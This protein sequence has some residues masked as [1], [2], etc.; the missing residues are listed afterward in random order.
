M[1]VRERHEAGGEVVNEL[2]SL[3]TDG[4]AE[5]RVIASGHDFYAAPRLSPDGRRVAWLSWDHPGMPWD[6][7]ELW[8]AEL[9]ADGGVTGERLVAGGPDE[10]VLQPLWS[11]TGALWFASDRTGWWNLYAVEADPAGGGASGTSAGGRPE[12][13]PLVTRA[14]EFA[15][16]PW[17]FGLQSYAFLSDGRLLVS[18]TEDGR[19]HLAVLD[20]PEAG[21]PADRA[22]TRPRGR[23]PT[24]LTSPSRCASST[25]PSPWSPR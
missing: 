22:P 6:G 4:S 20:A 2:V 19:D 7:T 14:A 11:P 17:V 8:T 12:P 15:T 21:A 9:A 16:V 13:C 3:P 1:S 24:H 5:P 25:R 18:F 10:S 23:I